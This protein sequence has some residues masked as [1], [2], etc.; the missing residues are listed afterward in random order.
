MK[1]VYAFLLIILMAV[2]AWAAETTYTHS[3][4]DGDLTLAGGEVTLR[5]TPRPPQTSNGW[6]EKACAL[7]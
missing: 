3:F 1:K 4:A 7:V 5:G 2:N 6:K